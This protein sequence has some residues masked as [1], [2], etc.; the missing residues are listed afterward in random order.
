M[1]TSVR[2]KAVLTREQNLDAGVEAFQKQAWAAAYAHLS[3]ADREAAIGP[4]HLV[5]L[6]QAALLLGKDAEGA[7]ILARA[8]QEFLQR[9]QIRSAVRCAFWLG[10]TALLNNEKAKAGGWLARA[11]RLLEGESD[12]VERGYLL[13]PNGYGAVHSG[14]PA[15]AQAIFVEAA[16]VGK[17][18]ADKDLMAIALQGQGRALIRQGEVANG[19]T[20]LDE[21]M[22]SVM[23]GEVSPLTAGG[24]Y[25][26]VLEACGEVYDLRR[27]H[28]WT[29]ALQRWC[30]SQ[31]DLVPYRGHCLVRR[32]EVLQLRGS[33]QDAFE[34]ARR[35]CEWLSEASATSALGAAYYQLGEIQ[36]LRGNLSEAEKAYERANQ[37]RPNLGPGLAR[38]RLVQKHVD[39]AMALIA[40]MAEEVREPTRRAIV[41]DA[42]VEIALAADSLGIAQEASNELTALVSGREVPLLRAL[43][44]RSAGALLVAEG[45]ARGALAHLRQSWN[46]WCDLPVPY[47]AARVRCLIAQACSKLGDEDN[48][49]LELSAARET[50][51]QLGAA[52]DLACV[53]NLLPKLKSQNGGP[54]T[55]REVE[56]LRLVA[57]GM[58]N[59][60]IAAT[61]NISEKTV[62][63]HMSNIFTKLDLPSRTAATAY[64]YD[65][66]LL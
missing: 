27:A 6:A 41:L 48:A 64:A 20:L 60:R 37:L 32:A 47:E 11:N 42:Y 38:L 61:L 59:R 12:C 55:D 26:S 7:D 22:I 31:P 29:F 44:L 19:L 46:L 66:G 56:V 52:A 23:A 33:W 49:V 35:A 50:F 28:E 15:T 16:A 45:D 18:F 43:A 63:R 39:A 51:E 13:L 10:F 8:H 62:A 57:S 25:C 53:K 3:A 30:E 5:G 14:D 34:E 58:T 2:S 1:K 65:H 40:R 54:L 36:R 9:E 21:A 17:R 4:E 24:V